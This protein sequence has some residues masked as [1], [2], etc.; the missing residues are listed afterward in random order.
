M[1]QEAPLTGQSAVIT[2]ASDGIGKAAARHIA[3][4]GANVV[5]AARREQK[6]QELAVSI[7][8]KTGVRTVVKPTDVSDRAAVD[9][10]LSSAVEAF[11]GIDLIVANA[12]TGHEPGVDLEDISLEQYRTVMDVNIDGMFHTAQAGLPHLRASAGTLIF[13]GSF[14][15]QYPRPNAPVYAA[16]KWWTR[17]FALSLSAAVGKDDVAISIINPSE[18][19]TSFG[20]D[21]WDEDELLKHQF[22]AGEVTEPDAIAKAIVFAARQDSPDMISELDLYRRD[23]FR[24]F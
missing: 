7:E 17:G 4:A 15:G 5:L 22:E 20:K 2:G 8:E 21:F 16:S 18:V 14:A 11:D 23:K 24:G 12:G 9:S 3:A 1:D 10:L 19:R 6:L 13:I